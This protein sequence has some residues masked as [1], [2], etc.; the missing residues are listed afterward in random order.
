MLSSKQGVIV[1]CGI[2]PA[3]S[4]ID[5][6]NMAASVID[7]AIRNAIAVGGFFALLLSAV[8]LDRQYIGHVVRR[9]LGLS[10]PTYDERGEALGLRLADALDDE[11]LLADEMNGALL[12][13][14]SDASAYMTGSNL[15]VD[16]GWTLPT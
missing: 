14:A 16:G 5:T 8:W 9:V 15:V 10:R 6:Y 13:L 2:N 1:A 3:Y 11:V 12:F 4:D 7:E